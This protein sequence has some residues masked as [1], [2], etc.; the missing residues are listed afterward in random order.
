MANFFLSKNKSYDLIFCQFGTNGKYICQLKQAGIVKPETKIVIRFHGLD[1]S[2]HT[3]GPQYY[4]VL[5]DYCDKILVGTELAIEQLK[6]LKIYHPEKVDKIPV[7]YDIKKFPHR[8][9]DEG[10]KKIRILSVGRLIEWKGH[11]EAIDIIQLLRT[12][13]PQL[14][15]EYSIIGEGILGEAL[16]KK[17]AQNNLNDCVKLRGGQNHDTVLRTMSESDIFLYPGKVDKNGRQ[18]N[19]GTAVGEAMGCGCV[20]ICSEVGGVKEYVK[21]YFNGL[22]CKVGDSECFV[23]HIFTAANDYQLRKN[24]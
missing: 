17:I 15:F 2:T 3:Y 7:S 5:N 19:Q 12:R 6:A 13:Y 18:E 22:L 9:L 21:H 14:E 24:W 23:E 1:L 11:L 16:K 8:K 4:K 10:L 20:V